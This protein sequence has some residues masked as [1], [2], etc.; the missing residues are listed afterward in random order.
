[1]S[2][3]DELEEWLLGW[4]DDGRRRALAALLLHYKHDPAFITALEELRKTHDGQE[5]SPAHCASLASRW[6]L[7]APWGPI[8]VQK[9]LLFPGNR[10]AVRGLWSVD[11]LTIAEWE[12]DEPL[13]RRLESWHP[14][15]GEQREEYLKRV[16]QQASRFAEIVY[17]KR[18]RTPA[19][20][21]RDGRA[22]YSRIQGQRWPQIAEACGYIGVD[23]NPSWRAA[24]AAVVRMAQL[25]E[26]RLPRGRPGRPKT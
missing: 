18:S 10:Q 26:I 14:I 25:L 13:L 9:T 22:L 5:P 1:M 4:L 24:K 15:E 12:E 3:W 8:L 23:G 2:A 6:G 7:M 16:P 20:T 17:G 21:K 19:E 11:F